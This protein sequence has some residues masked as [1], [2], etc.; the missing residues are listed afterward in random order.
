MQHSLNRRAAI[1][2]IIA[3]VGASLPRAAKAA[4]IE[5]DTELLDLFQQWEVGKA[6]ENS[7]GAEHYAMNR[8]AKAN[9]PPVPAELLQALETYYG[10]AKPRHARGWMFEELQSVDTPEAR[11]LLPLKL[12]FEAKYGKA[13]AEAQAGRVELDKI[14]AANT[15]L[16]GQIGE[17]PA[18]TF[19]GLLAK[20]HVAQVERLFTHFMD[21][22]E[23]AQSIIDD[24]ERIIP[25]FTGR[26]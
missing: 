4:S 19:Q 15:D 11:A 21:F 22:P 10:N 5:A 26:A 25:Q 7:F 18:Y 6:L 8:I 3:T 2:G 1:A 14:V 24:V 16:I 13:W 12:V 17:T 9:E 23:I 20:C